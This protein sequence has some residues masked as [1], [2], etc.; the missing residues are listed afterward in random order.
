MAPPR[1]LAPPLT[2]CPNFLI[3]QSGFSGQQDIDAR[4]ELDSEP[5]ALAAPD[6]STPRNH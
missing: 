2:R 6:V 5:D 3:L 1:M 4:T